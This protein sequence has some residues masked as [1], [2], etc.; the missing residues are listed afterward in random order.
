MKLLK[1]LTMEYQ[2]GSLV[3]ESFPVGSLACNCSV[4]YEKNSGA[5]IIVDPGN[6]LDLI[7]KYV[8]SKSLKVKML[9]HT[10]AHF[11]HIGASGSLSAKLGCPL[12]LHEEDFSLYKTLPMQALFFGQVCGPP[13]APSRKIHDE[14]IFGLVLGNGEG[15][16]K[17]T[18]FLKTL[19]TPGHTQGSCSFYTEYFGEP[20]LL[21]GDTLFKESIGRTD[22]PGGNSETIIRSIKNR[23]LTLPEE[24]VCI[25]GHGPKTS[26]YKEKKFNPYI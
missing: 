18:S 10:H 19:H 25:P 23:L 1:G 7:L 16:G 24:T 12:L 21:S 14:E 11:D 4:I 2:K 20:L 9:L 15:E 8:S 22:L 17:L 26:I 6:D 3:L 13:K 5:A